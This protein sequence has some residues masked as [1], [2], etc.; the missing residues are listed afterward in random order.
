MALQIHSFLFTNGAFFLQHTHYFL[1]TN[2]S[3][4][5]IRSQSPSESSKPTKDFDS[6]ALV[7]PSPK[8]PVSPGIGFGSSSSN[9]GKSSANTAPT[10]KKKQK[11]E[12]ERASIIRRS[13]IKKPAFVSE[14]DEGEAKEQTKNE[15]A[16]L[17]AWLGFGGVILI[18][19]IALAASG[20]NIC[21]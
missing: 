6:S 18:E 20:M 11:G 16:F 5:I 1:P 19:G 8:K 15:S 2:Q 21:T 17:L 3:K 9:L 13:P 7:S 10:G 14:N 4:L 12:R